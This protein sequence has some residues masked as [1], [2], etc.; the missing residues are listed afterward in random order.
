MKDR[1]RQVMDHYKLSQK[2]YADSLSISAG[3][4][5]SVLSGRTAPTNNLIQAIHKNF[6]AVNVNWL[7]FGEGDMLLPLS[8]SPTVI[9]ATQVDGAVFEPSPEAVAAVGQNFGFFPNEE[10]T[11]FDDPSAA[12]GTGRG[13]GAGAAVSANVSAPASAAGA[14]QS[15]QTT[16]VRVAQPDFS[17][18]AMLSELK[19]AN[20]NDKPLRRIKEIRVFYDDG[21]YEAFVPSSK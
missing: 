20:E 18:A 13:S 5:S 7:M 16:P 19:K 2:E 17:M 8:G 10:P 6:P 9:T 15:V 21:T 12:T 3:S 11:L 1:V 14:R 4:I